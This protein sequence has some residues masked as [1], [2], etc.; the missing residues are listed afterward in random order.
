VRRCGIASPRSR[1][2]SAGAH[3]A[4]GFALVAAIFV[5]LVLAALA[6]FA[7]RIGAAQQQTADFALL[8]ARARLAAESGIEYGINQARVH[9]SCPGPVTLNLTAAGLKGFTVRVTCAVTN[10][11]I[12][13]APPTTYHAWVITAVAQLG[14]YGTSGYVARTSTRT[15]TDAP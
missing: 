15:V 9:G 10:H 7:V 4:R 3:A 12:G 2:R 1:G 13:A 5:I 8:N 6:M 11:Q 14:A